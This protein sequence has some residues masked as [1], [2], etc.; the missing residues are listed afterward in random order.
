MRKTACVTLVILL[1][2]LFTGCQI[3]DRSSW[4]AG[5]ME[6][7]GLP[8]QT[9]IHINAFYSQ[10]GGADGLVLTELTLSPLQS[11]DIEKAIAMNLEWSKLPLEKSLREKWFDPTGSFSQVC[12]IYKTM[13]SVAQHSTGSWIFRDKT[14]LPDSSVRNFIA[15]LWD[16]ESRRLFIY[17][18]DS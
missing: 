16:E 3:I 6:E 17:T 12:E 11:E 7:L 14:P 15:V 1:T 4:V 2:T 8:Q 18:H 10:L 9:D 13:C 5:R